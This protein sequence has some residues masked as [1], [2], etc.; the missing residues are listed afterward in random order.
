MNS[1]L[2][3]SHHLPNSPLERGGS[4]PRI[5]ALHTII[6]RTA[7]NRDGV[8]LRLPIPLNPFAS[9]PSAA[10]RVGY[11]FQLDHPIN[12]P[13]ERGGSIPRILALHTNIHR[14]AGNRDGVCPSR[15]YSSTHQPFPPPSAALRVGY[16]LSFSPLPLGKGSGVR[17]AFLPH[18]AARRRTTE[19]EIAPAF[20]DHITAAF[21]ADTSPAVGT[22]IIIAAVHQQT[23]ARA[24]HFTHLPDFHRLFLALIVVCLP[25]PSAL[26]MLRRSRP[27]PTAAAGDRLRSATW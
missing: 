14:A 27:P 17:A 10:L 19:A 22:K 7:G 15:Q 9:P 6:R 12:S 2:Q 26:L 25:F 11:R 8:C 21:I 20:V 1:D 4:I 3:N 13:L 5:L 16:R 24:L 23:A 18:P